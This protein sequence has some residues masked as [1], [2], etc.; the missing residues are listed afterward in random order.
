MTV[1]RL[2]H[3]S[4]A[5]SF[6]ATY[7][8]YPRV[9]YSATEATQPKVLNLTGLRYFADAPGDNFKKFRPPIAINGEITYLALSGGGADG[10]FGAGALAGLSD[11]GTRPIFSTVSG[12]S[13]GALIAPFALLGTPYDPT[14]RELYT[15]GIAASLVDGA[16]PLG[17]L[18]TSGPLANNRLREL[19]DLYIDETLPEAIAA[20]SIRGRLPLIITT[21]LDT[22]RA[23]V[24]NLGKIAEIGTPLA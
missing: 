18:A 2:R 20:E 11:A 1:F 13:T 14:L 19:V 5:V 12:V 24:W 8:P 10:A 7:R 21:S 22:Q 3:V 4:W 16:G 23:S 17:I 15:S 9:H 6:L